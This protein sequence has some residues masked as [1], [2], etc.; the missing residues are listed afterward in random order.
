MRGHSCKNH[1]NQDLKHTEGKLNPDTNIINTDGYT[2]VLM[3]NNLVNDFSSKPY[4]HMNTA[5]TCKADKKCRY[6]W[7]DYQHGHEQCF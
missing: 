7:G 1:K 4:W 3:N 2:V 6:T 5:T